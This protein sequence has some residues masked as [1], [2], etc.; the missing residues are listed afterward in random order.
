MNTVLFACVHNAG[1][2]Q[3]AAAIFNKLADPQK[4][5]AVSAGTQPATRVHPEVVDAMRELRVDLSNLVPKKLTDELARGA[6]ILITMGC[7][8][9]C[10]VVPGIARDDWP[11]E[12][13]KGQPVERVRL[14]RFEIERRVRRL[15]AER[16]WLA[17]SE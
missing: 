4:A 6:D 15:L 12:D 3:M 10:P 9:E 13:P 5:R 8:D 14:I 2:S 17:T 1:R 11:L 7:G 16:G